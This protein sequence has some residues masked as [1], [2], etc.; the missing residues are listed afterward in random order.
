MSLTP[1]ATHHPHHPPQIDS[2]TIKFLIGVIA[3]LMG[4]LTARLADPQGITSIS[5]SYYHG[6]SARNVFV[7]FLYA[8]GAF[9]FAYNGEIP[10]EKYLSKF[11]AVAA[12]A[13]AMFPCGT[14]LSIP[15]CYIPSNLFGIP[16]EVIHYVSAAVMFLVLD[17]FSGIFYQRASAKNF[18]EARRRKIIYALCM[19]LITGALLLAVIDNLMSY[20]ISKELHTPSLLFWCELVALEAFGASWL[21]ASHVL[22]VFSAP[23]ERH[24]LF[25]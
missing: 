6:D 3:I 9:L 4:I 23:H 13:I 5:A 16:H 17:V 8:I 11:A 12:F 20:A 25:G 10:Q 7:G 19:V 14:D 24:H 1:Q 22:P 21:M 15:P 2:Q 18:A